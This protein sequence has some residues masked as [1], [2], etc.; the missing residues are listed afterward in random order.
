M[1]DAPDSTHLR[2]TPVQSRSAKTFELILSAAARLLDEEGLPGFNT[3]AIAKSAGINV[4]TLYHYFPHKNA[5]LREMAD[6]CEAEMGAEARGYLGA[7]VTAGDLGAWI[8][9]VVGEAHRSRLRQDGVAA[10]GRAV[11]AV[12]ELNQARSAVVEAWAQDLAA[13]L[14]RR[15]PSLEPSRAAGAARVLIETVTA[16]LDLAADRPGDSEA[17][18]DETAVLLGGYLAALGD[19]GSHGEGSL[20]D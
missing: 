5:I 1:T 14:G 4:A 18:L 11:R 2:A 8:R 19:K 17:I 20:S 3:N 9:G 10:L 15:L 13:A 16:L 6:R 7:L 12:P